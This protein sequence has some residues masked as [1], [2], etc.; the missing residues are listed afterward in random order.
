MKLKWVIKLLNKKVVD[1]LETF[2]HSREVFNFF[3][4]YIKLIFQVN[5]ISN[6]R[7]YIH[8]KN[9]IFNDRN[10]HRNKNNCK[11]SNQK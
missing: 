2:Y 4:D 6:I 8:K 9:K 5:F 7:I 1:T 3:R 10:K 11:G